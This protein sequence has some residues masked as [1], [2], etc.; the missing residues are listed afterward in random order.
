M[1][2]VNQYIK[3]QASLGT[4]YSSS[5]NMQL[6]LEARTTGTT[7]CRE[8]RVPVVGEHAPT[9]LMSLPP[10]GKVRLDCVPNSEGRSFFLVTGRP[11]LGTRKDPEQMHA[12]VNETPSPSTPAEAVAAVRQLHEGVEQVVRRKVLGKIYFEMALLVRHFQLA[13]EPGLLMG[14]VCNEVVDEWCASE[15]KSMERGSV[16]T[17]W[18]DASSHP[19]QQKS[20]AV[21]AAFVLGK[22]TALVRKRSSSFKAKQ[23]VLELASLLDASP[24][25]SCALALVCSW[26]GFKFATHVAA[27]VADV[28]AKC[29]TCVKGDVQAVTRQRMYHRQGL[30]GVHT[31]NKTSGKKIKAKFAGNSNFT[32]NK[33]PTVAANEYAYFD[34]SI[35]LA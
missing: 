30:K 5:A 2:Q 28:F 31:E 18:C 17:T 9:N 6:N 22:F 21:P 33:V 19:V 35:S 8:L 4:Q 15:F 25:P 32:T 14:L 11:K 12:I 34:L 13:A 1:V 29:C 20:T 27:W 10:K 26:G 23:V 16:V 24:S 7:H 3:H